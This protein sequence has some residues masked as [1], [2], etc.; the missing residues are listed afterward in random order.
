MSILRY[1]EC[2]IHGH[3]AVDIT[4]EKEA[5]SYCLRCGKVMALRAAED[6]VRQPEEIMGLV[7]QRT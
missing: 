3:P 7:N 4:F 2:V 6:K 5:Y 1:I